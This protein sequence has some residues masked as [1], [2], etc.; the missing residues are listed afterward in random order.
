MLT[1]A[2]LDRRWPR[3]PH[4]L[5]DGIMA[6]A[7]AVLAKYD[8][9][10][11]RELAHFLAQCSEESQAGA[12]TEENLH[13]SAARLRE[14]WPRRFPSIRAAAPFAHNPRLLADRVYNGRMGNAAGSDD[15]W[16]FRGRGLIQITGRSN[17]E[18]LAKVTG[19]DLVGHPELASA[20]HSA[21][22]VAGGFW[23]RAGAN[24][25]AS[26]D[27]IV[28]VTRAVNGGLTGLAEREAWLKTW[29]H[30]L[31]A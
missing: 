9:V 10:T 12:A 17:Y 15:G 11:P 25:L 20:P 24:G 21:L 3:A 26:R 27:D 5:V 4:S 30:E 13:Y 19:V 2:M 6:S 16:N 29:K 31:G 28:A 14:V 23:K 22:E 1:H 7:D 8:I 18:A